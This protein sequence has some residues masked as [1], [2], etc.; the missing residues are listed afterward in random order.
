MADVALLE[1]LLSL[2]DKLAADSA[3]VDGNGWVKFDAEGNVVTADL[4]W[5]ACDEPVFQALGLRKYVLN[6][7]ATGKPVWGEPRI[8]PKQGWCPVGTGAMQTLFSLTRDEAEYIFGAD[9]MKILELEGWET[10][11]G[12]IY[13]DVD[14]SIRGV[15]ERLRRVIDGGIE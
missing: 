1:V 5:Y 8:G 15:T 11:E 12:G 6:H 10:V 7:A 9:D 2:A 14:Y 4:A 3:P 13:P